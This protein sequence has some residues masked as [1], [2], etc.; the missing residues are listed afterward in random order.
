MSMESL[1][2]WWCVG[3][4]EEKGN[5]GNFAAER[6]LLRRLEEQIREIPEVR[7][8][9]LGRKPAREGVLSF[10]IALELRKM[11]WIVDG[12]GFVGLAKLL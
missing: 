9:E 11:R 7:F 8:L 10:N 5:R 3:L 4:S 2:T 1:R 6:Q 12:R